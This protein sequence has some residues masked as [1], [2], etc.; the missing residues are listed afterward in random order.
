MKQSKIDAIKEFLNE[1]PEGISN[2]GLAKILKA[3]SRTFLLNSLGT[4][5]NYIGQVKRMLAEEKAAAA[6]IASATKDMSREEIFEL[7]SS[8]LPNATNSFLAKEIH[9]RGYLQDLTVGSIGVYVGK[10]KNSKKVVKV[11]KQFQVYGTRSVVPT[12]EVEQMEM[13]FIQ[14]PKPTTEVSS[15][16]DT[17]R[18]ITLLHASR[19]DASVL[20]GDVYTYG[21]G[22]KKGH[23]SLATEMVNKWAYLDAIE[24]V[25]TQLVITKNEV[26]SN[27]VF[28]IHV[29]RFD[30]GSTR[31]EEEIA[32]LI[33]RCSRRFGWEFKLH[34][35]D[36]SREEAG[37]LRLAL[38]IDSS[39]FVLN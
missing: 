25:I 10:W 7:V 4:M 19:T 30:F 14:E 5:Q 18:Q 1:V 6:A 12:P 37:E 11:E 17:R 27:I 9:N 15:V 13:D 24:G 34:I 28:N 38:G 20:S 26:P 22:L 3:N 29:D 33:D 23:P 8:D 2:S 31:N 39:N 36:M 16:V 35:T 32:G 21:Q